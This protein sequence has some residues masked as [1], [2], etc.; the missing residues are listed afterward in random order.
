MAADMS[1]HEMLDDVNLSIMESRASGAYAIAG[2]VNGRYSNWP[3]I[4]AKYGKSGKYL[5]SIDVQGNPGA[6]AQCLDVEKGDATIAQAPAWFKVTAANG[7]RARD[8]RWYPKL[9]TSA[10]NAEALIA[11][12]SK[13]DIARD[14]YMLWSAHYTQ[15]AHICGP[16]TCGYP[17][18]DATQWTSAFD[19]ASLDASLCYG[20]F[21]AGPGAPAAAPTPHPD[22]SVYWTEWPASMELKSGDTGAAVRVLQ[23]ACCYSGMKGVRGIAVDG[24]FGP[25]TLTAVRNFQEA[26]KLAVDGIAGPKTR[27]ALVALK[28]VADAPPA[29]KAA[30]KPAVS[31][32]PVKP[33]EASVKAAGNPVSDPTPEPV[34]A[35]ENASVSS[36][37]AVQAASSVLVYDQEVIGAGGATRTLPEG[38]ILFVPRMVSKDV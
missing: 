22:P 3:A 15:K 16:R 17:Q 30:A 9:Y 26:K 38:A 33:A 37:E 18:A 27:A 11:E 28:D 2:Y 21:F 4:V 1:T 6:G 23:G 35:A 14:A 25:Q 13:A 29:A 34:K 8:L 20:Y 31:G 19:G 10:G 12:M 5:L 36:A 32:A 7:R 24:D